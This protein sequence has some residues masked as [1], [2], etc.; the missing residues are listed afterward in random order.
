MNDMLLSLPSLKSEALYADYH[1]DGY[2][3]LEQNRK[4]ACF[5]KPMHLKRKD[6]SNKTIDL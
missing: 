1:Q 5:V 2:K 4:D 3:R 6:Q